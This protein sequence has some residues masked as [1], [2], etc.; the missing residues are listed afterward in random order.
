MNVHYYVIDKDSIL[1]DDLGTPVVLVGKLHQQAISL[2]FGEVHDHRLASLSDNHH[3][4]DS[5][6]QA[7]FALSKDH[8]INMGLI[9]A[10]GNKYDSV[11]CKSLAFLSYRNIIQTLNLNTAHHIS[12]A[13]CLTLWQNDHQFC[14]R[15]GAATKPHP[16]EHAMVCQR[17]RHRAYP[18]VQPC[19]IV[20]IT[21]T[22]PTTHQRQILLALHHRHT[23]SGMYGLIAG[24]VEAG[25]SLEHAV[26]RE[27]AEEVG[28]QI[29]HLRYIGSQPW[30]YPS[31]LM[32]G[33]IADYQSGDIAVQADELADACFFDIDQLPTIPKAGTIAHA[34]I[35]HIIH[36]YS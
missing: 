8:A 31:N 27:V 34:L 21:R 26:H 9:V 36:L 30:P 28:I 10:Y 22:H 16:L 5:S 19:V 2:G 11:H 23:D 14:S 29:N 24:F 32:L 1:C 20:A 3:H 12:R 13:I 4:T 6:T 18:R 7:T 35:E 33:F 15:C 25:E 17:C